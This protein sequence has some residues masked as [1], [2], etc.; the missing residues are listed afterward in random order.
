MCL[1][2]KND[3]ICRFDI[4]IT[5]IYVFI[6]LIEYDIKY[7]IIL[8]SIITYLCFNIRGVITILNN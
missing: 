5:H 6:I 4:Y 7:I 8:I 1:L 2:I 3:Y